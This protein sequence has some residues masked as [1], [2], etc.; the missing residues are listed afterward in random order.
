MEASGL[1]VPYQ[2]RYHPD[3]PKIDLPS[4]NRN[5][6][7]RIRRAIEHRLLTDPIQF[8]SPL[9]KGLKGYRKLR[10]GDYRV[11][12]EIIR[13]EIRIYAIDHR[14]EVYERPFQNRIF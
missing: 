3:V 9:R 14:K 6:Q 1:I 10:V 12:Y 4:I 13:N 11:V 7:E 2:I 5:I 8:G